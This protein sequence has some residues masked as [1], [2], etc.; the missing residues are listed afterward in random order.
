MIIPCVKVLNFTDCPKA[1]CEARWIGKLSILIY[2][3]EKELYNF[4]AAV[5]LDVPAKS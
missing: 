3:Y 1:D 2:G 5:F 4:Q